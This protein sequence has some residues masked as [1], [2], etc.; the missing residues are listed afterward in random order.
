[1]YKKRFLLLICLSVIS[2]IL[3]A[4]C[5]GAGSTTTTGSPTTP[6]ITVE[7][8][9]EQ[10]IRLGAEVLALQ[11]KL[12]EEYNATFDPSNLGGYQVINAGNGY[13]LVSIKDVQKYL[14]GCKVTLDIG[15]PMYATYTGFKIKARYGKRRPD[16]LSKLEEWVNSLREKEI[17][18]TKS[19]KP[20]SWNEA[21]ITLSPLN[22]DEFGHLML[23]I[24]TNTVS[25]HLP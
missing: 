25:L 5:S 1:M 13:F 8:L 16:D 22:Y 11:S 19:L 24:D 12:D 2:A 4:S 21:V 18:S 7:E 14:D 6:K 23:S 9:Q 3:L 20:G 10:I 17:D 15:N